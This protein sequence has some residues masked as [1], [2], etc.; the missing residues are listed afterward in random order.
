MAEKLRHHK[1]HSPKTFL[2]DVMFFLFP[3]FGCLVVFFCFGRVIMMNYMR[4]NNINPLWCILTIFSGLMIILLVLC[5]GNYS[6]V[7]YS[8]QIN[9]FLELR[10]FE[11][12]EIV[13]SKKAEML[14]KQ[15][16][17]YLATAYPEHER[18]IFN[19]ISPDG[20]DI[21]LAKY[22][23][24][25]SADTSIALVGEISKLQADRYDQQLQKINVL[26]RI[27]FRTIDPWS[28][29][30]LIPTLPEMEAKYGKL[31]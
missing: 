10:K 24:L 7:N 22:P 1:G 21:Y 30:W 18:E 11:Q 23:E 28:L 25:R 12:R 29:P 5:M 27:R 19:S 9:D 15:F 4:R 8:N 16:A 26:K 31:P 17:S 14:T 6:L 13:Y 20:I 3:I 2:E